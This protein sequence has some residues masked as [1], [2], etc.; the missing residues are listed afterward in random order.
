MSKR[1]TIGKLPPRYSFLLNSYPTFR[2][3]K[4]PKCER[5]THQRKFP[6]LILI[7]DGVAMVLGKTCKY[8]TSCEL[9]MA[10]RDEL[11]SELAIAAS[12]ACP[13]AVGN[14]YE[15]IGTMDRKV[16]K[17]GLNRERA[18][19]ESEIDHVADFKEILNLEVEPGGWKRA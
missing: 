2:L 9:I 5:P 15:V 8:C 19:L 6:L 11:E 7:K 13:D 18:E 4:C 12:K 3:S 16:W 1:R 10:F 17:E 14:D